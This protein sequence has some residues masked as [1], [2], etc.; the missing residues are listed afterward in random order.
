MSADAADDERAAADA[1]DAERGDADGEI[2]FY[3]AEDADAEAEA[4][5]TV[6]AAGEVKGGVC[7][8]GDT[9]EDV[10]EVDGAVTAPSGA[11]AVIFLEPTFDGTRDA[12]GGRRVEG[13]RGWTWWLLGRGGR[14]SF[15]FFR[16][17]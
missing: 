10:A 16:R 6:D 5:V 9:A 15:I 13:M 8:G 14:F 3:G 12:A 7:E 2:L 11:D 1:A 17:G 4:N